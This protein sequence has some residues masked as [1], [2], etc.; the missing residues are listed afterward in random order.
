MPYIYIVQKEQRWA[1]WDGPGELTTIEIRGVYSDMEAANA[2]TRAQVNC[3][4]EDEEDCCCDG[5]QIIDGM[6]PISVSYDEQSKYLENT[7]VRALEEQ[8]R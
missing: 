5:E 7:K 3:S 4:C 8:L 2:C 6:L 1:I